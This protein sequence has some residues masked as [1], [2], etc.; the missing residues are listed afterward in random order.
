MPA[1]LVFVLTSGYNSHCITFLELNW[2]SV[3]LRHI[4]VSNSWINN[5]R[6]DYE[7]I[8]QIKKDSM[9]YGPF[10]IPHL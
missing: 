6:H 10:V 8:L 1:M 4:L 2:L 5:L 7:I 9:V 3:D